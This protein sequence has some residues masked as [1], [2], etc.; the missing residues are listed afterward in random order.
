MGGS[1]GCASITS[2]CAVWEASSD[3]WTLGVYAFSDIA[4]DTWAYAYSKARL[5]AT[6]AGQYTLRVQMMVHYVGQDSYGNTG[7]VIAVVK[8]FDSSGSLPR[9]VEDIVVTIEND[10]TPAETDTKTVS[11]ELGGLQLQPGTCYVEV[12]L[13]ALADTTPLQTGGC[14]VEAVGTI[15]SV[16]LQPQG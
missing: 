5:E 6:E 10:V 1:T 4:L 15:E 13:K 8:L 11:I 9:Q 12:G 7:Y 16:T 3:G 2:Y 14:M